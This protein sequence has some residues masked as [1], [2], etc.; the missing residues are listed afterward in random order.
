MKISCYDKYNKHHLIISFPDDELWE[1]D[2]FNS[3]YSS[4]RVYM[5][6]ELDNDYYKKHPKESAEDP[7]PKRWLD[8]INFKIIK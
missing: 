7:S 3:N 4:G 2:N 1:L 6:F 5:N 8:L